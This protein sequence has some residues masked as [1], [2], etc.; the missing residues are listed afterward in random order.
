MFQEFNQSGVYFFFCPKILQGFK[1][2]KK[3]DQK[4]S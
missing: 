3:G 4:T 1:G 2:K